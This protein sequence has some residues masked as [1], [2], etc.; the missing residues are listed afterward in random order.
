[1]VDTLDII[2]R[3]DRH[4]KTPVAFFP[5]EPADR[6]GHYLTCY[7]HVGQHGAAAFDYYWSTLP[8]S[9]DQYAPLHRELT[10]IYTTR[11]ESNPAI[12]GAPV[13]LRICK[14]MTANHK[15]ELQA[16]AWLSR[17]IDGESQS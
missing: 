12:Y 11:P 8:A 2:Y 4:D 14:R 17:H 16:N 1:M 15:R 7:A 13:T 3:L 10:V 9:P 6:Y 5:S